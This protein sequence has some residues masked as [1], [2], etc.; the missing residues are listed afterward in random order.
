MPLPPI[1]VC[2]SD[3]RGDTIKLYAYRFAD[4]A[5]IYYVL[6]KTEEL[7]TDRQK[8]LDIIEKALAKLPKNRFEGCEVAVEWLEQK[9]LPQIA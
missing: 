7:K 3:Q 6:I 9:V 2:S 5:L 4:L 8:L 1:I